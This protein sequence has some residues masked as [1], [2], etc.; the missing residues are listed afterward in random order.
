M[1]K[2]VPFFSLTRH[3]YS[4]VGRTPA[5]FLPETPTHQLAGHRPDFP[6]TCMYI[7]IYICNY[8]LAGWQPPPLSLPPYSR[9]PDAGQPIP[10]PYFL[11]RL[12]DILPLPSVP[13]SLP[14]CSFW[15]DSSTVFTLA[16][17]V[18]LEHR[19]V[20]SAITIIVEKARDQQGYGSALMSASTAPEHTFLHLLPHTSAPFLSPSRVQ[21]LA[22]YQPAPPRLLP[23]SFI[24]SFINSFTHS[25]IQA[26]IH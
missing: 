10:A 26:F 15:S 6:Y 20:Y 1:R 5:R 14:A 16:L 25:F 11:P 8:M 17:I 22:G 19:V 3:T 12:P 2:C 9:W 18:V 23:H 21:E 4:S 13:P 7:Y 24:H